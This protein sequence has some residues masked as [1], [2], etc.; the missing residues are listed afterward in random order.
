MKSSNFPFQPRLTSSSA[1]CSV[2]QPS[3]TVIVSDS[4]PAAPLSSPNHPKLV[5]FPVMVSMISPTV[6]P[7]VMRYEPG[8]SSVTDD[9]H[10]AGEV[11]FAVDQ[12]VV[13]E[14]LGDLLRVVIFVDLD[15][16]DL[17]HVVGPRLVLEMCEGARAVQQDEPGEDQNGRDFQKL[18]EPLNHEV[19]ACVESVYDRNEVRRCRGFVVGWEAG[20]FRAV[21]HCS[22]GLRY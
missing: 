20:R 9:A 1:I 6:I 3:M 18:N 15:R 17:A 19:G 8:S 21:G 7:L 16:I 2:R 5:A 11:G 10:P 13:F 22:F 14:Q 12:S 4:V